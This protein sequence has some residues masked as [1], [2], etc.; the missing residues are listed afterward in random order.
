MFWFC[1]PVPEAVHICLYKSHPKLRYGFWSVCTIVE[2]VFVIS[3]LLYMFYC[4]VQKSINVIID[5][6]IIVFFV[7][8]HKVADLAEIR[9]NVTVF[10]SRD[11]IGKFVSFCGCCHFWQHERS[12]PAQVWE[13][14]VLARYVYTYEDFVIVTKYSFSVLVCFHFKCV[15]IYILFVA[16]VGRFIL[17]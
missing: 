11:A 15:H 16:C 13:W 12:R 1:C 6:V 3:F 17:K 9:Y 7:K 5:I 10:G 14:V 8:V 2:R 4:V